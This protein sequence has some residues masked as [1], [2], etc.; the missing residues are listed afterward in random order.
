MQSG[1]FIK[2]NIALVLVKKSVVSQILK[3]FEVWK[4]VKSFSYKSKVIL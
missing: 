1:S 3:Y 2:Q 4:K